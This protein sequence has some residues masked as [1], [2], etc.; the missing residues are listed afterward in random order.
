MW[1]QTYDPLGSWPVS[2]LVAA[3]PVLVLLGLLASGKASAW[4]SALAGLATAAAAALFV[5]KM[6]AG[7]VG[8]GG[9]PRRRLRRVPDRLADRRR[10]LPL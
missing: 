8:A 4:A 10:G 1:T 3:L 9:D 6:P 7:M 5:F 2:T